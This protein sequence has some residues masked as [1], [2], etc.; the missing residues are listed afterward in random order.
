MVT[1]IIKEQRYS[2]YIKNS[3]LNINK[4]FA[5]RLRIKFAK[6]KSFAKILRVKSFLTP[7][8]L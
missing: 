5:S 7:T 6:I 8:V 3:M 4:L 1:E 2:N